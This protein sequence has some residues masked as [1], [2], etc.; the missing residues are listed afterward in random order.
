MHFNADKNATQL[1]IQFSRKISTLYY[2]LK[3]I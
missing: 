2:L 3:K 1:A